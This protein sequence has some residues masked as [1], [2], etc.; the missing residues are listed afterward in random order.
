MALKKIKQ[1]S[2]RA[3]PQLGKNDGRKLKQKGAAN[4][5]RDNAEICQ[6]KSTFLD[7]NTSV[8]ELSNVLTL[9]EKCVSPRFWVPFCERILSISVGDA[10][11]WP[12]QAVIH[13]VIHNCC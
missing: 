10:V 1:T 9:L 11:N 3:K 5:A 8:T 12:A 13:R 6:K 2:V 4:A 7:I